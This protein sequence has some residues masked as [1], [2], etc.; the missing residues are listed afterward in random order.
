VSRDDNQAVLQAHLAAETVHDLDATL[1]TVHPDCVFID[2]QLGKRWEGMTGA[3]EHYR[4]WWDG[5]GATLDGGDVHWVRD[6]LVIGDAVFTGRHVGS[7]AGMAPTGNQ[8][9]LPFVVFVTFNDTLIAG[10]RFVYDMAG[11]L[12]QLQ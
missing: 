4:T 2:E 10:E 12:R 5:L 9:R 8:I 1:A 6:D 3:A 11:L 7:F